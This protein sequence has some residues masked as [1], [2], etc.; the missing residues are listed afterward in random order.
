MTVDE[1]DIEILYVGGEGDSQE[2]DKPYYWIY[3]QDGGDRFSVPEWDYGPEEMVLDK[4]PDGS[5]EEEVIPDILEEPSSGPLKKLVPGG[6]LSETPDGGESGTPCINTNEPLCNDGMAFT[7]TFYIPSNFHPPILR[8]TADQSQKPELL[9][10]MNV[11]GNLILL[12]MQKPELLPSSEGLKMLDDPNITSGK[13]Q[14]IKKEIETRIDENADPKDSGMKENIK[15]D[16]ETGRDENADPKDSGVKAEHKRNINV[17]S[18]QDVELKGL[19]YTKTEYKRKAESEEEESAEIEDKDITNKAESICPQLRHLSDSFCNCTPCSETDTE[20]SITTINPECEHF[21]GRRSLHEVVKMGC[22]ELVNTI[23]DKSNVNETN[24]E[25]LTAL[26]IAAE[27]GYT[28]IMNILIKAGADINA[29]DNNNNTALHYCATGGSAN[30]CSL[31]LSEGCDVKAQNADQATAL[32]IAVWKGNF[33]IV[34]R[35]LNYND[36]FEIIDNLNRSASDLAYEMN[37]TD[38]IELLKKGGIKSKNLPT[39]QNTCG[40]YPSGLSAIQGEL[41]ICTEP[42]HAPSS[43]SES[44]APFFTTTTTEA[45]SRETARLRSGTKPTPSTTS[46]ATTQKQLVRRDLKD[47]EMELFNASKG[48]KIIGGKVAKL[49]IEGMDVNVADINSNSSTPLH[50]AASIGVKLTTLIL[51]RCGANV[52]AKDIEGNTPLHL[53]VINGKYWVADILLH[54]KANPFAVN[55]NGETPQKLA[56]SRSEF[57]I[58]GLFDAR[59]LR[60]YNAERKLKQE[61]VKIHQWAKNGYYLGISLKCTD[62]VDI[63]IKNIEN[64]LNTAL[65]LAV[66]ASKNNEETVLTLLRCGADI[67]SRDRNENTP[68]HLAIML[69]QPEVVVTLLLNNADPLVPNKEGITAYQLGQMSDDPLIKDT[70]TS[71]SY[72]WYMRHF[73][74]KSKETSDP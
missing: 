41:T 37:N 61:E 19:A 68:L 11:Y 38:I 71:Q 15:K 72:S 17:R 67:H 55:N 29:V 45:T 18:N 46:E 52:N 74:D 27:R 7:S 73:A 33:E 66:S 69:K 59:L 14:N 22:L 32:H 36:S 25:G 26:Q 23:I 13:K 34:H 42:L 63:N 9:P 2:E 40:R 60:W 24:K 70:F 44:K 10:G 50:F 47:K 64:N 31:L 28:D 4:F 43:T 35:L 54:N 48:T 3:D 62:G 39:I 6:I 51:I 58:R 21:D 12:S 56:H 53:A 30:A 16:I 8:P 65:H 5:N 57:A 1:N 49:C 20:A